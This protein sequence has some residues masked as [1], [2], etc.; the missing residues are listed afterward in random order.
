[1]ETK[2]QDYVAGPWLRRS[3]PRT[4][5]LTH[6]RTLAQQ[7]PHGGFLS[8]LLMNVWM[9]VCMDGWMDGW[10]A[11]WM[12]TEPRECRQDGTRLWTWMNSMRLGCACN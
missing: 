5:A 6:S 4:H 2:E 7:Q 3:H 8:D 12:I 10:V 11:G 9:N 1:V